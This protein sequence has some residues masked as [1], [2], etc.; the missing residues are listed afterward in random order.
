ML[1][2]SDCIFCKIVNE[3]SSKIL[4]ET[5]NLIVISD[6]NPSADTHILII[7][8]KHTPTVLDIN[9]KDKELVFEM[10]EIAQ[11]LIKEKKLSDGYK[12]IFNGGKYQF[13]PHL[14]LHLLGGNMKKEAT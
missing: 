10:V 1:N 13:V 4:V 14:H 5:D 2:M 12:L 8:K 7:P 11:K 9:K 6:I 3:E